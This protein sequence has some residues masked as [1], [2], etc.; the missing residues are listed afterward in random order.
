MT[1]KSGNITALATAGLFYPSNTIVLTPGATL[2]VSPAILIRQYIIDDLLLL[3]SP[4]GAATWPCYI[5]SMPDGDLISHDC[6]CIYDT[7]GVKDGRLMIGPTIQ[8]Y[9]IQ[10]MIRSEEYQD[11]WEKID[12]I[13]SALDAVVQ[14]DLI[15]NG[16]TYRVHNI[17][18][19]GSILP[20]GN[21]PNTKRRFLF[22]ANFLV[23]VHQAA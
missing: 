18:R 1:L 6:A 19:S 22:T 4:S 14:I 15:Y 17:S 7:T 3:Q 8:H 5:G 23:T 12:D 16:E 21:E 20:L 11:G 13:C 2:D 10:L 9:G